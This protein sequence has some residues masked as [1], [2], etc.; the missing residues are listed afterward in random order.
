MSAS[1]S[2][3]SG[4]PPDSVGADSAARG[5]HSRI[6]GAEFNITH[7][8][9]T[10]IGTCRSRASLAVA[11][12][13]AATASRFNFAAAGMITNARTIA[14]ADILKRRTLAQFQRSR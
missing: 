10:L 2:P 8:T 14:A 9:V 4:I 11:T 12:R 1:R 5:K 13:F 3:G 6:L 7:L